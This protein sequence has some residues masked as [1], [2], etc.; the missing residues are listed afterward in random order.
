[1]ILDSLSSIEKIKNKRGKSILQSASDES[2]QS[3]KNWISSNVQK[4]LWVNEYEN[5]LKIANG[6][7]FN[8]LFIYNAD[9]N[10]NNGFIS[11]NEV[12]RETE[13]NSNYLFFGDSSI[14]WFCFDVDSHLFLELDKPSGDIMAEYYSFNKMIEQAIKDVL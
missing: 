11:A 6:L 3:I 7:N 5:F 9:S 10:D 14:A 2:I 1:M 13:W 4:N 12:W 8:G